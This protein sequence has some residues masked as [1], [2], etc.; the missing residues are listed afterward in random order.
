MKQLFDNKLNRSFFYLFLSFLIGVI[1]WIE[2]PSFISPFENIFSDS[3]IRYLSSKE[4]EERIAIIDIDEKSLVEIGPWP[5]SR[6]KIADLIEIAFLDQKV[7]SVGLDIIFP[8]PADL[9]GDQRLFSLSKIF[10]VT[11]A[12]TFDYNPNN[13]KINI[14]ILPSDSNKY[15]ESIS[16]RSM[17]AYGYISNHIGLKNVPC[18]GNIG[19]I[20][21]EDGT[22]RSL[23]LNSRYQ[24]KTYPLFAQTILEC[25]GL[26]LKVPGNADGL[27]K[28]RF[29]SSLDSL[30]FI[31]ASDILNNRLPK[32]FLEKKH[33]L[34]GSSSLS[35][36]DRATTPLAPLI[37][38][39]TVHA[40]ALIDL[41]N[42]DQEAEEKKYSIDKIF[43][44]YC[45]LSIT[46]IWIILIKKSPTLTLITIFTLISLWIAI[47]IF[48]Y[49]AL[50]LNYPVT[51]L[52]IALL[53]VAISVFPQEWWNSR[54]REIAL[55]NIFSSYV[56]NSVLDELKKSKIE[57]SLRPASKEI[58]VLVVDMQGYTQ[59]VM[60]LS[61]EESSLLTR[62][63]LGRLTIPVL[64]NH[65]TLDKYMG[66]G[67]LAFWGAPLDNE[68]QTDLAISCAEA[69][70]EA[71]NLWNEENPIIFKSRIKIRIGIESGL[72]LVGDLGTNFRS[73]Y[74]AVGD[75][76]NI[77]S[78]LESLSKKIYLEIAIGPNAKK[79]SKRTDLISV[80]IHPLR[81]TES[82][83]E[84]FT[85][86]KYFSKVR[87]AY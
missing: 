60:D 6:S 84:V 48:S 85:I 10:P 47:S 72:A 81:D 77:A 33:I 18:A 23:P 25:A 30:I 86:Q 26:R 27:W 53:L 1:I 9:A 58:T 31:S 59:K 36:G 54:R 52:I 41:L 46:I 44:T 15:I 13:Q 78:R 80:G 61:L 79:K 70:I 21:D 64:K 66:D 19:Y 24:N 51:P 62:D 38:G 50:K 22:V 82:Y 74:T 57:N 17:P 35:L 73:T 4:M 20:P 8:Y 34:V 12:Y 11:F 63:F 67:L 7:A 40:A 14:G 49:S 68:N 3:I 65:G 39:V 37:A 45:L 42:T 71:I 28:L 69:M 87:G 83:I 75:C 29:S 76:I 16:E 32:N 55:I 43:Y 2:K 5:W 56:G